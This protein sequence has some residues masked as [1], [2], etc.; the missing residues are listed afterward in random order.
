MGADF[1]DYIIADP[2]VLPREHIP[3]YTEKPVCLPHCYQ[4]NDIDQQIAPDIPS[5]MACGLPK[6]GFVFCCFNSPY[7]IEPLVFSV[8]MRILNAVPGSVLWLFAGQPTAMRNLRQQA[9]QHGIAADRLIFAEHVPKEQHLARHQLADLFLDTLFYNAHTT[10]SDALW[11]GVPVLTCPGNTFA[12]RVAASLLKAVG[13]DEMIVPD[14]GAYETLA[15]KLAASRKRLNAIRKLLQQNRTT[16]PLFDTQRFARDLEKAYLAIW[17][18]QASGLPPQ[19]I[20]L[21]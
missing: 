19:P 2:M 12:S 16:M 6:Q 21:D 17:Q 18:D 15:V 13:L 10:A 11:A 3:Y 7:K 9:E 20:Y 5:R 4:V 8:W 1:I 14:L